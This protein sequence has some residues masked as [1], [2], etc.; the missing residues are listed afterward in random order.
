MFFL[1][2]VLFHSIYTVNYTL[3]KEFHLKIYMDL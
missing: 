3:Y 2:H 1:H